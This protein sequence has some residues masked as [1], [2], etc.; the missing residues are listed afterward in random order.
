MLPPCLI[1]FDRDGPADPLVSRQGRDVFPSS[2][3]LC[4]GFERLSE[5]GRKI[6][7]YSSRK[8]NGCHNHLT[9]PEPSRRFYAQAKRKYAFSSPVQNNVRISGRSGRKRSLH[10]LHP[11]SE[12]LPSHHSPALESTERC[13]TAPCEPTQKKG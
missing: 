6:M 12:R 13:G 9:R 3:C 4:V 2:A 5:I 10:S 8:E 7:N 1:P 11:L